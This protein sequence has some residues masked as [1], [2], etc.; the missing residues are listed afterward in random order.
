MHERSQTDLRLRRAV[1][2]DAAEMADVY[3]H[4]F[5][6]TYDFPPAHTE[7]E[8]RAWVAGH[9]VQ[10]LEAWVAT[11]GDD[12]V[13]LLALSEEVVEQLYVRPGRTGEGI[14][15]RLAEL[16]K[17]RRPGGLELWTFQVNDGA[18]RF[19]AAHGF[20]EVEWTDGSGNEEGQPDVR[21][22]WR[23]VR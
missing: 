17:E 6:A 16:A 23:P 9:L 21:F 3:L 12:I 13:A 14:G 7:D 11:E 8:V 15:G 2:A 18:R 22:V 20:E 5:G 1:A 4:A 10:E 19:Y